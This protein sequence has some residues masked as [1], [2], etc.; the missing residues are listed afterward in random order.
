VLVHPLNNLGQPLLAFAGGGERPS[1]R[2][3]GIRVKL[4][5]AVL[6]ADPQSPSG[7]VGDRWWLVAKDVNE[8][9]A[10]TQ[11]LGEG[12]RAGARASLRSLPLP[13]AHRGTGPG[14]RASMKSAPGRTGI[15]HRDGNPAN[16]GNACSDRKARSPAEIAQAPAPVSLGS[17]ASHRA[18]CAP[19]RD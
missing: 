19:R 17:T 18:P 13:S 1:N 11:C 9:G 4:R 2:T 16:P 3:K 15:A 7:T 12:Q 5:D 10:L 8:R 6:L 14:N